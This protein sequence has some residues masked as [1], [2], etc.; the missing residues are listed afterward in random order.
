MSDEILVTVD[1]DG[2]LHCSCGWALPMP[3]ASGW[4]AVAAIGTHT[5]ICP[6]R[7]R[8]FDRT[9]PPPPAVKD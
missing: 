8:A 4:S 3:Y 2:I 5:T 1:D 6:T 9:P 7:R